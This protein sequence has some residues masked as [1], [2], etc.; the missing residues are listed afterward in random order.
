MSRHA[1]CSRFFDRLSEL[2]DGEL[3]RV[4]AETIET[5]LEACPEQP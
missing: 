5:H 3:D 2:L 4:T 1:D